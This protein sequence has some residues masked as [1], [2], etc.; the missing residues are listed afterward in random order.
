[1]R[2]CYV[3]HDTRSIVDLCDYYGLGMIITRVSVLPS[4]RGKGHARELMRR[5]LLDADKERVTLYL[6]ILSSGGLTHDELEA[7]YL[8]LGFVYR[9]GLYVR[10]PHALSAD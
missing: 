6:E 2:T 3:D 9:R 10:R 5:V 8:R 1:M 7:W 4:S